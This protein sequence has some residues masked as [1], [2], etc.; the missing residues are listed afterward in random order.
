MQ[1]LQ[2]GSRPQW[3]RNGRRETGVRF[4]I[5]SKT[6]AHTTERAPLSF[7]LLWELAAVKGAALG[8]TEEH[9]ICF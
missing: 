1:T 8:F 9:H 7:G 5:D 6:V 4:D 3:D 2:T